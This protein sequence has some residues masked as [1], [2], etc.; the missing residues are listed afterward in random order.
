[1]TAKVSVCVVGALVLLAGPA[2]AG[3]PPKRT[4]A[5]LEKGR[6]SFQENCAACHGATGAGDGVVASTL[7]PRPRNFTKEP[8]KN[9]SKPAQIFQTLARGVPGSQMAAFTQLSEEE[10]WALAY[11]VSELASAAKPATK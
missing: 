5:L 11:Y 3:G 9:G 1:M 4:P 7:D 2:G 10:R 8:F 6:A